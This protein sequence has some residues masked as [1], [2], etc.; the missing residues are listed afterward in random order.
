VETMGGGG[1]LDHASRVDQDEAALGR[2]LFF[3]FFDT[4][5]LVQPCNGLGLMLKLFSSWAGFG[6]TAKWP[7]TGS[8]LTGTS[9]AAFPPKNDQGAGTFLDKKLWRSGGTGELESLPRVAGRGQAG[10]GHSKV[11]ARAFGR[12]QALGKVSRFGTRPRPRR[13]VGVGSS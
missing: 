8:G 11:R 1:G 9:V 2:H 4:Q 3:F 12:P 13:P 7:S 6:R 10:N 5:I